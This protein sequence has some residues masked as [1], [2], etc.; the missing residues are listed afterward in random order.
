MEKCPCLEVDT[1]PH[2]VTE[3]PKKGG[4]EWQSINCGS[5]DLCEEAVIKVKQKTMKRG[6]LLKPSFRDYDL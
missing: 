3:L 6:I 2:E 5:R 4:K 1:P